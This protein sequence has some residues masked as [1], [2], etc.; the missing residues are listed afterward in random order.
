MHLF[1]CVAF[2]D[3]NGLGLGRDGLIPTLPR[4]F[5]QILKPF[6][7]KKLNGT[8]Q[9]DVNE[10]ISILALFM[11]CKFFLYLCFYFYYIKVNKFYKK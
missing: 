7:F 6:P 8:G 2:R 5:V 4:L 9:V 3:G 11:F 1:T 10:K